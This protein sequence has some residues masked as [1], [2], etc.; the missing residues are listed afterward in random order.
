M[1]F[2]CLAQLSMYVFGTFTGYPLIFSLI[3]LDNLPI[4]FVR[5]EARDLEN[6]PIFYR[7][8]CHWHRYGGV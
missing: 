1:A 6:T 2:L 8:L 5:D 4:S 3:S 7:Y